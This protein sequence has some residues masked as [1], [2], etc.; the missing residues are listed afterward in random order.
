MIQGVLVPL[1]FNA[2]LLLVVAQLFDLLGRQVSLDHMAER[3]WLSGLLIG[4]LGILLMMSPLRLAPGVVFDVRSV[5]LAISGLFFGILPTLVAMLMTGLYRLYLGGA[6]MLPGIGVILTSGLIGLIWRQRRGADLQGLGR[7]ELYLL[8]L[9]VHLVMLLLMLGLPQRLALPTLAQI[10]LPVLIIHPLLTMLVGNLLVGRLRHQ[11]REQRLRQSEAR[12]RQLFAALPIPLLILDRQGAVVDHNQQFASSFGYMP[13]QLPD[14]DQWLQPPRSD[15]S[16]AVEHA[17]QP[18]QLAHI[19]RQGARLPPSECRLT[20]SKGELLD[21]IVQAEP[22]EE[23]LLI[24]FFDVTARRDA[25]QVLRSNQRQVLEEQRCARLA[26]LNLMEDAVAARDRAEQV[27]AQMEAS[28]AKYRQLVEASPYAIGICQDDHIVMA[29]AAAREMFGVD[30]QAEL[31]GRPLL[32]LVP[33]E[34]RAETRKAINAVLSGRIELYRVEG[35]YQTLAGDPFEAEVSATALDYEGRTALQLIAID[36]T[37]R[38][39]AELAVREAA[40]IRDEVFNALPD[41]VWLKDVDGK[42]LA[43]NPMFER[44]I[45]AREADIIGRTDYDFVPAG[46]ADT[47]RANDSAAITAGGPRSNEEWLTFADDN[48]QALVLTTKTPVH[49]ANGRLMGVLGVARDITE[50]RHAEEKLRKLSL[51][52]AQSPESIVITN[53]DA[54]IEYVNDAFVSNSGYSREDVLGRNPRILQ[55]GHTPRQNYEALWSALGQGR[56]WKGEFHNRR[57]NGEEYVEFAQV[58]PLRQPDG[59]ISHYVAVKEDITE[60]KRIAAELDQHRHHLE[61]L[62]TERTRELEVARQRA[63]AANQAKSAFLAN[64]SHEIRTPLNAIVGLVH[65]LQTSGVSPPQATRLGKIDTAARHLM[66]IISDILDLSKIEAGRL[67]LEAVDFHPVALLDN[68]RSLV[69]DAAEAK[70]VTL[71]VETDGLPTWL[72]GDSLRLRQALLNLAGN[73]VKFT[74]SGSVRMRA[75]CL[76]DGPEGVRIRF[77][78]EDTG[79]GIPDE[80]LRQLFQPF[81]QGDPSITRRFGG[82]GL[83][84]VITQRLAELMGGEVGAHSTPGQ[85]SLFW[86]E[87]MLQRGHG[88]EPQHE[89]VMDEEPAGPGRLQ[90]ARVLLVEDNAI[91]R[92]VAMELLHGIG[93]QVDSAGDGSEALQMAAVTD[94]DLILMDLQMPVMDGLEATRRIRDLPGHADTP[95]LAMTANVYAEDR[96]AS[97]A[98]GMDDFVAKPVEPEALYQALRHWLQPGAGH[99]L[100]TV[101][102]SPAAQD[103]EQAWLQDALGDF[104]GLV[105]ESGLAALRGGLASYLRLLQRFA[106]DHGDDAGR[107]AE[108]LQ[109]DDPDTAQRLAHTLKGVAG[110]LGAR[111]LEAAA[112]TVELAL[113]DGRRDSARTLLLDDLRTALHALLDFIRGLPSLEPEKPEIEADAG[114]ARAVL[115]ELEP[116]LAADDIAVGE[117]FEAQRG[118]L[119]ATL[120]DDMRALAI[121]IERFDFPAALAQVRTLQ[122]QL[123][124][125]GGDQTG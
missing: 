14:L 5:L 114:R 80:Q 61:S 91:N 84:L 90:S 123:P 29:N 116:L 119:A 81:E 32:E 76:S 13:A 24:S 7:G 18:P 120:G 16:G 92:E 82:T 118:L 11:T 4:A 23:D 27:L 112:G 113:R 64:M 102:S 70:G 9:V 57:K 28:E 60:K 99:A 69:A 73:A 25:E 107:L 93:L 85:G 49:D 48:H 21:V 75:H 6:G 12:F 53:L 63:E 8:G 94:Y 38:K 79:I 122:Q 105:V 22:L 96:Q 40:A 42:F 1:I 68:V 124:S 50:R 2:A 19:A 88:I 98:A 111:R 78:V 46:L 43:C 51:A 121:A 59:T 47:F 35:S 101:P 115:A 103:A 54:E 41:L 20:C 37:E 77:E 104:D 108:A 65:L 74:D 36:I 45:G 86:L 100:S 110:T 52:V 71:H 17:H 66:S 62:V 58:A 39:R 87:V 15:S 55:S 125:P 95:I 56:P 44:F 72:Y 26:S 3:I 34:R 10:G 106:M 89:T 67:D 30:D 97:L 83:G 109:S 117:L 31:L 33:E